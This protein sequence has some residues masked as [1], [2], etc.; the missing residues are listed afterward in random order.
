ML[1][2]ISRHGVQSLALVLGDA[3]D[4]GFSVVSY[5][6]FH[7]LLLTLYNLMSLVVG[8]LASHLISGGSPLF[9]QLPLKI[10][11]T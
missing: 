2:H 9:P 5:S 6:G 4:A 7:I 11:Y 10:P 8:M 3:R 1:S